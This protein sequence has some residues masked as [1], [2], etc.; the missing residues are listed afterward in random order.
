MEARGT[1]PAGSHVSTPHPRQKNGVSHSRPS[2]EKP[3]ITGLSFHRSEN[4]GSSLSDPKHMLAWLPASFILPHRRPREP[5][6]AKGMSMCSTGS[7]RDESKHQYCMRLR[8]KSQPLCE[9]GSLQPSAKVLPCT[10]FKYIL[11]RGMFSF[12]FALF[13]VLGLYIRKEAV[14]YT[15]E[16]LTCINHF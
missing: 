8:D 4:A 13:I 14:S 16:Q 2:A 3:T 6:S 11:S 1:R 12:S 9:T 5:L 15:Y 7:Q 10:P